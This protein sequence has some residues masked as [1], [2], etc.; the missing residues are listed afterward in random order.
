[1]PKGKRGGQGSTSNQ[2]QQNSQTNKT[3]FTD[4]KIRKAVEGANPT[5]DD[6]NCQRCVVA[7]AERLK[8]NKVVALEKKAGDTI[9]RDWPNYY[10][11]QTWDT[12]TPNTKSRMLNDKR[13]DI[14]DQIVKIQSSR[15]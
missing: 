2:N 5:H 4:E 12:I 13:A 6:D 7:V 11:N 14:K 15:Y 8:G 9:I 1:M 3:K 10:L